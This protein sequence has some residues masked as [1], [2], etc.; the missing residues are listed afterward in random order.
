MRTRRR[1][2]Q[3]TLLKTPRKLR[4]RL[5]KLLRRLKKLRVPY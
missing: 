2:E 3:S 4:Y 1:Y 5:E